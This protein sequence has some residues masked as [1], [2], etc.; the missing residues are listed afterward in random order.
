M[1]GLVNQPFN[2]RHTS[3][4]AASREAAG[5][6]QK[7]HRD[8]R[9]TR[10]AQR[11]AMADA[12]KFEEEVVRQAGCSLLPH[13]GGVIGSYC[14]A[15]TSGNVTATGSFSRAAADTPPRGRRPRRSTSRGIG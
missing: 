11:D 12:G 13:A 10:T 15:R 2:A 6:V 3:D 14:P 5:I 1:V 4:A 8:A 7:I 9:G